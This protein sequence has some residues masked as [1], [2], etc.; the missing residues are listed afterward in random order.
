MP[1]VAGETLRAQLARAPQL[2]V[3]DAVRILCEV[4]RALDYA[5]RCG[6]VH[7]DV[8]PASIL[9]ADGHAVVADFGIAR[10]LRGTGPL[11]YSE[12][13]AELV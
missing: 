10:A 9:L 12:V 13:G 4:A 5:H 6:V 8:K 3:D 1:Y 11:T 2:S 7:S